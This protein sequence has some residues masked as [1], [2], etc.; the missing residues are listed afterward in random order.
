MSQSN[1]ANESMHH[2]NES[3]QNKKDP[4]SLPESTLGAQ[5]AAS[6]PP[7]TAGAAPNGGL[8]AWTQVLGAHLLFFNS[9]YAL[10]M[11][12]STKY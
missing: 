11:S 6:T 9:W 12:S 7:N 5:P 4:P 8:A 2:A 3:A 10:Y 1:L